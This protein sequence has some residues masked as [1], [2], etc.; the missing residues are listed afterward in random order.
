MNK[1]VV[2]LRE[3]SK[4]IMQGNY[5]VKINTEEFSK[6]YQDIAT[7]LKML[8]NL[9]LSQTFEMQVAS[10][11]FSTTSYDMGIISNHQNKASEE[12]KNQTLIMN[13]INARNL[14]QVELASTK[15]A[16]AGKY[17][18][19]VTDKSNQLINDS[20]RTKESINNS[21]NTMHNIIST[22]SELDKSAQETDYFMEKL[23]NASDNIVDILNAIENFSKQTNLLALNAAIEAARAGE[24]GQGFAVVAEEV[25]KLAEESSK[26]VSEVAQMVKDISLHVDNVTQKNDSNKRNV[27]GAVSYSQ[28]VEM[29]LMDIKDTYEL[30]Q[31]SIEN[32]VEMTQNSQKHLQDSDQTIEEA[33]TSTQKISEI[34]EQLYESVEKQY[35]LTRQS[36]GMEIS[37]K[38]A[39][40][41]LVMINT[42]LNLDLLSQQQSNISQR[43]DQIKGIL[44]NYMEDEEFKSLDNSLI[45]GKLDKLLKENQFLEAI[46]VN[47]ID[48][49]FLYSNPPAGIEN[50]K[51][52]S[53]FSKSIGGNEYVSNTYISAISKRPCI[54]V[55]LPIMKGQE[56][57]GIIGTDIKITLELMNQ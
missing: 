13:E 20:N 12:I 22:I 2:K 8:N 30:L 33:Y 28:D 1:Q 9:I 18:N 55:S 47:T 21:L 34:F 41:N 4:E 56:I 48:G 50:G 51:I 36:K 7:S 27:Q 53:W 11:Q 15:A 19:M 57:I 45:K 32:I 31:N 39:A 44:F 24:M 17:M 6:E 52:R 43:V 23:Q 46:W 40:N 42:K 35:D 26:S 10:S 16:E 38:D 54:T 37:L 5:M 29:G 3:I 25:R 14:N 49:E